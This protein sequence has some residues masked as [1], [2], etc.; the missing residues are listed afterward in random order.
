MKRCHISSAISG[1]SLG[2]LL[3][4]GIF[5]PSAQAGRPVLNQTTQTIQRYFGGYKTRLT[6]NE[7]ITYTYAP[8]K[9]KLLFPKFPKS[10]F[11]I[12]F[13]NNKAKKITLNF[14]GSFESF[15]GTYNYDQ[16][17]AAKFYNYIFGYQPPA[18]NELSRRFGGETIYDYQYCLGDGVGNSFGRWGYK[19]F[20]DDASLYY[21][22]RCEP[23]YK[24]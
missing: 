13:V 17:A 22:S 5:A 7:G 9:F 4:N 1:L 19:Q 2:L 8:A 14:N 12:T 15:Q 18:W 6:T 21:D 23:P 3:L 24:P 16:A 20:T 11:S 10:N